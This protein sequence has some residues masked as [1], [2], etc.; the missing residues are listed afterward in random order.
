MVLLHGVHGLVP[1]DLVAGQREGLHVHDE[2]VPLLRA[3]VQPL[4]LEGG[5]KGE[6]R[7]NTT[8]RIGIMCKWEF[9][10]LDIFRMKFTYFMA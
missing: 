9:G 7:V 10:Y 3:E 4:V 2:D 6:S 1:A 5:E 8:C